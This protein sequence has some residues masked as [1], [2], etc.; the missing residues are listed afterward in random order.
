M[1]HATAAGTREET[2][3]LPISPSR[4]VEIRGEV[5]EASCYLREGKR[6]ESHRAC[7]LRCLANGGQLAIVEDDTG[8][9]YPLAGNTPAS[10]PNAMARTHVA[11]HVVVAGQLFERAG[12]RVLVI[13]QIQRLD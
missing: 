9:L 13:E 8:T 10:D 7:A 11:N 6:G 12:G 4:S 3:K 1:A 2:P 5:V